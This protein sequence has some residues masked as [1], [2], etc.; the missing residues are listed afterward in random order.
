MQ[1]VPL[2]GQTKLVAQVVGEVKYDGHSTFSDSKCKKK[3]EMVYL[4]ELQILLSEF[5]AISTIMQSCEISI[6]G[7]RIIAVK[8]DRRRRPA[9][10]LDTNSRYDAHTMTGIEQKFWGV[11]LWE[12]LC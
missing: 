5:K 3:R 7:S 10:N 2:T 1:I 11:S 9:C 4:R 8:C 12:D 6:P